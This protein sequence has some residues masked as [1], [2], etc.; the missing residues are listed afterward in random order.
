MTIQGA[1]ALL[2]GIT[3]FMTEKGKNMF[4]GLRKTVVYRSKDEADWNKARALLH[5]AGIKHSAWKSEEPPVGGCGSK[6]DIRSFGRAGNIPKTIFSIE[7][8]RADQKP[9]AE[10]LSGRVLKPR[11]YGTGI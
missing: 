3:F 5:D 4:E 11:S 7:V 9:A 1:K 10:V 6:L 8:D 2:P